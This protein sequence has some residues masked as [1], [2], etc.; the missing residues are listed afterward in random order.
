MRR[1]FLILVLVVS[2]FSVVAA[3]DTPSTPHHAAVQDQPLRIAHLVPSGSEQFDG[4]F[5]ESAWNAL[6][7]AEEMYGAEITVL[8][9]ID[10]ADHESDIRS[11]AEDGYNVIVTVGFNVAAETVIVAKDYPDVQFI[12]VD[13]FQAETI[14]NLTGLIFPE[15][16]AGFLAGVLAAGLTQNDYVGGVFG[17]AE[18]PPVVAFREGYESGVQWAGDILGKEIT[19]DSTYHP[20]TATDAFSD[21]DWGATT[22]AVA[23]DNGADV[24]FAAAG[25]TGNGALVEVAFNASR[26]DQPIYCIGV[27]SDQWL[28]VPDAHPCLVSS[29]KKLITEGVLEL[30]QAYLDGTIQGG[31]FLGD[32]SLADFHDFDGQI[33]ADVL[34]LVH[35]AETGLRLGSVLTCYNLD[36][37]DLSIGLVTDV[38]QIDD[39][40]FNESAWN[41]VLA[42]ERCGATVDYIETQDQTDY[43]N[44]IAEFTDNGYNIIVTVGFA[45]GS[46]T[47][48]AA[49]AYP[50]VYFVGIDQFQGDAVD[51]VTGL[52]FHEDQAGFLAGFLAGRLTETNTV[53]AV[54]GTDQV[55][56][57]VAFGEGFKNGALY[58]NEDITA[59]AIYH[60][61]GL[62]VAFTDPQWGAAT[63]RQVL[64][65]GADVVFG[66][67]GK[68][69][70][71]ALIEVAS[72]A[73][74]G[75][76]PYCIGVDTDQWLTVPEAHP[77][78]ISSAMKLIDAGVAS[79]IVQIAQGSIA[80]GNTY[81]VVGLASFHDF[82][83]TVP[84]DLK[85]EI[86]MLAAD[87]RSG[88]LETGYGQ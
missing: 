60:P 85:A 6:V 15:D 88:R 5:N 36:L 53:A 39:G 64:D 57:V 35:H 27:D 71:G 58:A 48:E 19:V 18:V 31:N 75:N 4:G 25:G 77:C 73:S 61:G 72:A 29:A 79:L 78:L 54:L 20:G 17:T 82:D 86:D 23:L 67:G 45:L 13:Q 2:S 8:N 56:P 49:A 33:P 1:L 11:L 40:S 65:Q 16:Q 30:I 62:D 69:G 63:A 22:A 38:G 59:N 80:A 7:A 84:D 76:P 21:P 68:T 14:D 66:A 81:G 12:G 70:N 55:P 51:N 52:V 26:S 24:V 43:A 47:I 9:S 83:A 87:L 28:T 37:S 46:A 42:T 41:G 32:V 74:D 44:N 34:N 3:A 10:P 50:D